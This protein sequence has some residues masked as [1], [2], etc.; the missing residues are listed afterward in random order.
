MTSALRVLH[1]PDVVGGHAPRL[2]AAERALGLRSVSVAVFGDRYGYGADEVIWQPGQSRV[3]RELRRVGLF[4][5]AL[6]DFDV[7][8]FNFG[9]SILTWSSL[10]TG[11]PTPSPAQRL[12]LPFAPWLELV[13]V[14]LLKRA[15]KV[16]AVTYQ[17]D[18]ARQGDYT[19]S[20]H[21]IGTTSGVRPGYYSPWSDRRKRERVAKFCR[22]ADLVY[23]LNPDLLDVLPAGA[24]F[25]PY[26]SVNPADWPFV[27]VRQGIDR[28]LVVLHA[29]SHRGVKG[30][31]HIIE[32]VDS[33][34]AGGA[35]IELRVVEGRS[36]TEAR[37]EYMEA[38]VVVDQLLAGW[39]GGLAVEAMALGKPVVAYI[40]EDDLRHVPDGLRAGL[41]I[42]RATPD[43]IREVLADLVRAPRARLAEI[44]R[45]SRH[46]V[47][48]WHDPARIAA[49]LKSEYERCFGV[50]HGPVQTQPS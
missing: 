8:H 40:R 34:R 32:A 25:L 43:G 13:D 20:H 28:P 17:G 6:R 30:T 1:V 22:Y 31:R 35:A 36:N 7:I 49:V 48:T 18:D 42:V 45:R 16:I 23:A 15:G 9:L 11:R 2:A 5:R 38:D 29:P 46:F 44:G 10:L 21:A 41:P 4:L 14:P 50:L 47:E 33:L 26:A 27:G 37:G 24:S 39:Y 19:A 12:M 3:V